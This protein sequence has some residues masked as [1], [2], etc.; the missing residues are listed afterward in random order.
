MSCPA[1]KS[2]KRVLHRAQVLS[3]LLNRAQTS[4]AV[5]LGATHAG[6]A[7]NAT[8]VDALT[9]AG[10]PTRAGFPLSKNVNG[11]TVGSSQVQT[12]FELGHFVVFDREDVQHQVECFLDGVGT[13]E[14][15][16]IVAPAPRSTPCR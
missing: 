8:T 11:V 6:D 7:L 4:V 16:V 5:Q 2:G 15:P 3:S 1:R 10:L 14:G 9:L 13:I 12:P